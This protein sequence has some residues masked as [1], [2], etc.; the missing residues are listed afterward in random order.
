MLVSSISLM[1]F[2]GLVAFDVSPVGVLVIGILVVLVMTIQFIV[3]G[4]HRFATSSLHV[5]RAGAISMV[6]AVIAPPRLLAWRII[7]GIQSFAFLLFEFIFNIPSGRVSFHFF[8]IQMLDA[9]AVFHSSS[10]VFNATL[11]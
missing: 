10:L 3:Y 2:L 5:W 6:N 11:S 8:V 4:T 9:P 1:T 7:F